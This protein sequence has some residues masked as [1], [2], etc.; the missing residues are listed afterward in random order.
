MRYKDVAEQLNEREHSEKF[1]SGV[2]RIVG[3][4]KGAVAN[5]IGMLWDVYKV[6]RLK[7]SRLSGWLGIIA[8]SFQIYFDFSGYSDMAIGLAKWL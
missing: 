2:R 7:S 1:A 5:N 3:L 4:Q 8:F 6:C